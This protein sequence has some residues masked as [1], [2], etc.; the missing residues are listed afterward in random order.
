MRRGTGRRRPPRYGSPYRDASSAWGDDS[1]DRRSPGTDRG[2]GVPCVESTLRS[3]RT[4][5]PRPRPGR[6]RSSEPESKHCDRPGPPERISWST[7]ACPE[8]GGSVTAPAVERNS[9]RS[10][11]FCPPRMVKLNSLR[12]ENA[13]RTEARWNGVDSPACF[14]RLTAEKRKGRASNSG[15]AEHGPGVKKRNEFRSTADVLRAVR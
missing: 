10:V 7:I 3:P 12:S 5:Q 4:S 15:L 9:F 1:G 6:G 2:A 14:R 8:R 13:R 11:S